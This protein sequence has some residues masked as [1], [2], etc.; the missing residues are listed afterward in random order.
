MSVWKRTHQKN[1]QVTRAGGPQ[2]ASAFGS[3]LPYI[4]LYTFPFPFSPPSQPPS[5]LRALWLGITP[6]VGAHLFGATVRPGAGDLGDGAEEYVRVLVLLALA[7]LG[8][9]IWSIADRRR[10]NYDRFHQWLCVYVRM[11]LGSE[12]VGYGMAKVWPVQFVRPIFST[13]LVRFGDMS[14]FDAFWSTMG[15]SRIYTLFAGSSEVLGGVLLFIPRLVTLGALTSG[16]ALTNVLFLNLGYDVNVKQYS[17]H[18]LL[19]AGF[20]I[21]PGLPALAGLLIFHRPARLASPKFIFRRVWLNRAVLLLQIAY[22]GYAV[23]REFTGARRAARHYEQAAQ[24][25]PFSGVWTV[26]E[27]RINGRSRPALVTDDRRWRRVIFEADPFD[28]SRP[29]FVVEMTS[30]VRRFFYAEFDNGA[31]SVKLK[32]IN[33]DRKWFPERFRGQPPAPVLADFRLNTPMPGHLMLEGDFEGQLVQASLR[34]TDTKFLLLDRG[35]HWINDRP[36]WTR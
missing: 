27:L 19:M 26:D 28:A 8:T 4:A 7:V 11:F 18:L 17:L 13:L 14:P 30:G 12:M 15:A 6:W 22:G 21:I 35:F 34:R 31:T 1:L 32:P 10:P 20:L 23:T 2:R 9:V 33:D 36:F 16:A 24:N 29:D 25:I 5:W 3:L